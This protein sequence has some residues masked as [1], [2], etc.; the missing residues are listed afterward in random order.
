MKVIINVNGMHCESCKERLEKIL[1]S[2]EEIIN[3]KVDLK[4]N[5]AEIEYDNLTEKDLIELIENTG[6]DA[7]I[8]KE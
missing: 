8:N 2:K 1:N 6:F 5:I 4:Q 3:A 7:T